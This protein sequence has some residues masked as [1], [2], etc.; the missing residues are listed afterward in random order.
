MLQGGVLAMVDT[1]VKY[2]LDNYFETLKVS[3]GTTQV[4]KLH[5]M[6][7]MPLFNDLLGGKL[8]SFAVKD[9]SFWQKLMDRC[10][11]YLH[12][13]NECDAMGN[14][15]LY[16]GSANSAPSSAVI[17]ANSMTYDLSKSARLI[18]PEGLSIGTY[19]WVAVPA[20]RQLSRINNLDFSGDYLP[21]TKFTT[22]P[23]TINNGQYIVYYIK[24]RMPLKTTY[25]IILR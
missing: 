3:P 13:G 24:S 18:S 5:A 25:Q 22:E 23:M 11:P 12:F 15:I 1:G 14:N 2:T 8:K 10:F 20:G 21:A 4:N 9:K 19:Y 7:L 16:V 17:L 6:C